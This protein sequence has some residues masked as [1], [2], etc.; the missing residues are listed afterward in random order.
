MDENSHSVFC[1]IID[2]IEIN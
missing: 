2:G 1:V